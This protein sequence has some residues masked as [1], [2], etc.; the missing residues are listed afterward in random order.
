MVQTSGKYEQT[1]SENIDAYMSAI[2]VPW[3]AKK[4]ASAI[5]PSLGK[6][7]FYGTP[8]ILIKIM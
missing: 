6:I 4:A 3:I 2:G 8:G 7:S 5:T 1:G